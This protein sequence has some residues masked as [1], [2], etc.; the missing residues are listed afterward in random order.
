[1][2]DM[3]NRQAVINQGNRAQKESED[4]LIRIQKNIHEMDEKANI[5]MT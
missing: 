2:K 1:M 4:A 5:V 3:N